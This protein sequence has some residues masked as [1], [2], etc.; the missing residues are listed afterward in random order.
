MRDDALEVAG[1]HRAGVDVEATRTLPEGLDGRFNL[2][3]IHGS[4]VDQADAARA[5]RGDLLLGCPLTDRTPVVEHHVIGAVRCHR[6]AVAQAVDER[7][8]NDQSPTRDPIRGPRADPA[9][10]VDR[11]GL[12]TPYDEPPSGVTRATDKDAAATHRGAGAARAHTGEVRRERD[13]TVGLLIPEHERAG[14]D[15]DAVALGTVAEPAR[16]RRDNVDVVRFHMATA[17]LLAREELDRPHRAG[18]AQHEA[19]ETSD[20]SV[21]EESAPVRV[22]MQLEVL[23]PVIARE[24]HAILAWRKAQRHARIAPGQGLAR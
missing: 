16:I 2:E 12:E 10:A 4:E 9:V 13:A 22:R 6:T 5:V 8:V 11:T 19:P 20:L 15:F 7:A 3:H 1:V 23:H 17:H 24:L 21:V 18:I 14:H